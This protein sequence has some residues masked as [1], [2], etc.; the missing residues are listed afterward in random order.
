MLSSRM[1]GPGLTEE[2]LFP[3]REEGVGNFSGK[4]DGVAVG[5]H[6]AGPGTGGVSGQGSSWDEDDSS[7]Q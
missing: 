4:D 6:A 7:P 2:T 5:A 1:Q 3:Q